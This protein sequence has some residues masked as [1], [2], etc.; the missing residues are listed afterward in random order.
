MKIRPTLSIIG[1][2]SA[3]FI[4]FHRLQFSTANIPGFDGHYHIKL[5]AIIKEQGLL[6]A[7]P[8]LQFTY[9]KDHFVDFHFLYHLLLIPFTYGDLTYGAKISTVVFFATMGA[10]FYAVLKD[11]QVP[12]PWFWFVILLIGSPPFLYRMSLPR[13]PVTA[14]ALLLPA[15]VFLAENKRR[16]LFAFA[17]L[18]VWMYGGFTA[19]LVFAGFWFPSQW[20]INKS[21]DRQ[22]LFALVA[23]VLAGIV[24]NPYFPEN[25]I[26]LYSQ[27]FE[28]GISRVI[29]GG[30][31]WRPY[32]RSLL[33]SQHHLALAV[34]AGCLTTFVLARRKP[35]AETLAWLLFLIFTVFLTLRSQRFVEYLFPT[36]IMTSA[37]LARDGW[38]ALRDRPIF[39]R[40]WLPLV[41]A[42]LSILFLLWIFPGQ[43]QSAKNEM[44]DDRDPGRYKKAALWLM[45]NTPPGTTVYTSDWDDF[46]ELFFYNSQ[47]HYIVGLDPAFLY[48]YDKTL[49]R[50]WDEINLGKIKE[51]PYPVLLNL[52]RTP[53]IFTD[54]DHGPFVNLMNR[55]P[56]IKLRYEDDNTRIYSLR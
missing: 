47:N 41:S 33:F 1:A 49:Y 2:F 13:A 43:L 30:G 5:A 52:F 35:A 21:F 42:G 36:L 18:F 56:R 51:D 20:A 23:G 26:F 54:N 38:S 11:R 37:L 6:K 34:W 9:L 14:L 46:P 3:A 29:A 32:D 25:T 44:Y 7:L 28:A 53:Y 4:Y 12:A 16:A 15:T 40:Q 48:I 31:E 22:T 24:I 39:A 45:G 19:L 50:K 55:H 8:W 17:F 27:T 10:V